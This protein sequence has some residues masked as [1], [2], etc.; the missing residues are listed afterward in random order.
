V[1]LGMSE[2]TYTSLHVLISLIGIGS[3]V[4]VMFGFLTAKRLIGINAIFLVTT[5][6]TSV[7]GFGFPFEHLL[8][9]HIVGIISLVLLAVAIPA[10]YICHL[11]GSWRWIYVVTASV[12][13]YLNVF[14]LVAQAFLKVP[15]L[16]AL[17]PTGKEPPFLVAQLA[18][19][20]IFVLLTIPAVK[21]FHPAS[22]RG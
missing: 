4:V 21:K 19:M 22:P 9:S 20:L 6:L 12:A 11:A 17:A 8:P 5:V 18:V 3:G 2:S 14:V 10:L 1:I 16:H 15:A 7:T 13:L